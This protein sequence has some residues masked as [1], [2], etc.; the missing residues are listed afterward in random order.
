[1]RDMKIKVCGMRDAAN[2]A[3]VASLGPDYMGF[4]FYPHSPRFCGGIDPEI[5]RGLP[6]G[7]TPVAVTVNMPE[8]EILGL[9]RIYGFRTFQLHGE[10]S[11]EKCRRL[12]DMGYTVIKAV[13][14]K[15]GESFSRFRKYEGAVDYL[16]IDTPTSSRGGSGLKFDWSLLEGYDLDI[17]FI[18]S[19]GIAPGDGPEILSLSH[20]L[21]AGID[22]NSR[23]ET[24]PALKSASLL[25]NF[26][27]ELSSK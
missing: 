23:F 16:L 27:N 9:A 24:A 8:E 12:R 2:V 14:V 22:I 20:P 25:R 18:L 1:M 19:G 11:P 21:M 17:P 10:E 4:I 5:V 26:F 15:S 7:V 3:E 13:S 6:E